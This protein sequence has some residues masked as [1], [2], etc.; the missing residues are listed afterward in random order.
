MDVGFL[1]QMDGASPFEKRTRGLN[2]MLLHVR[3]VLD[4]NRRDGG[5]EEIDEKRRNESVREAKS[6]N[7]F[8]LMHR[9]AT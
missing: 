9:F 4:E 6:E 7:S 8:A 1:L 5:R 3:N 2:T